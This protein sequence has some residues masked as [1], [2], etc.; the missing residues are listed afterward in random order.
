MWMAVWTSFVLRLPHCSLALPPA[1]P[2]SSILRIVSYLQ[3]K[4]DAVVQAIRRKANIGEVL[5]FLA[6]LYC[7]SCHS[8]VTHLSLISTYMLSY[9]YALFHLQVPNIMYYNAL[10]DF[11]GVREQEHK[12]EALELLDEA[13]GKVHLYH[14]VAKTLDVLLP[15]FIF[16]LLCS[17]C[18]RFCLFTRFLRIA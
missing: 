7:F 11:Y 14:N 4:D 15:R 18:S 16:F 5:S 2:C 8:P 17:L 12:S 13:A 10:L 6:Y 3:P 9:I 1:L